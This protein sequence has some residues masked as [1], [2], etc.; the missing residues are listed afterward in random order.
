MK[1][2]GPDHS[3]L[4]TISAFSDHTEE[5]FGVFS[6]FQSLPKELNS[7]RW[8]KFFRQLGL[9]TTLTKNEYKELCNLTAKKKARDA[10][11]CSDVLLQYIFSTSEEII[12]DDW[13]HDSSFLSEVSNIAFVYT[14]NTSSVDWIAPGACQANQLVKLHG[15]ASLGL[16]NCV[17]TVRPIVH[18][19]CEHLIH[20]SFNTA[21][22]S[23]VKKIGVIYEATVTVAD[24]VENV[25]NI[26]KSPYVN[27]NL[28][29]NYPDDLFP[30]PDKIEP[31][32]VFSSLLDVMLD[33]LKTLDRFVDTIPAKTL[34][35]LPCIPVYCDLLNKDA[36]KIVLVKPSCVLTTTCSY[37]IRDYHPFL[38]TLPVESTSLSSQLLAKLG[39]KPSL[40]LHHM[41]VVLEKIY[42][43][44]DGAELDP[45]AAKCVKKAIEHLNNNLRSEMEAHGESFLTSSLSPL[46]LPNKNGI[47]KLSTTLLYCDTPSFK[48]NMEIDLSD[49]C[50]SLFDINRHDHGV[51]ASVLCQ[52][53]PEAVKPLGL[54]VVCRQVPDSDCESVEHT[55]LS[56]DVEKQLQHKSNKVA[57]VEVY[58]S[59]IPSEVSAEVL[60]EIVATFFS[61]FVVVTKYELKMQIQMK[62][63]GDAIGHKQ[64]KY[65][66]DSSTSQLVLYID[67]ELEDDEDIVKE[68]TER[69]YGKVSSVIHDEISIDVKEELFTFTTKYLRTKSDTQKQTLLAEYNVEL[70]HLCVHNF[71]IELGEDVPKHYHFRL[72]QD[73][74]NIFHPMEM[75]GYED[76]ENHFIV[77]QVVYLVQSEDCDGLKK[78]YHI[79]TSK[80][81]EEG[82][83]VSILNL[84]KFLIGNKKTRVK[85][86][87]ED[88]A[89]VPYTDESEI[90][91][92]RR[93][94]YEGDLAAIIEHIRT[95]LKEIWK[96]DRELR[97]KAVKRLYLKWHPDKNL[98]NTE[99]AQEVFIFLKKEIERLEEDATPV[100]A[101]DDYRDT[102][103]ATSMGGAQQFSYRMWDNMASSQ[104]DAEE[105]YARNDPSSSPPPFD[106]VKRPEEGKRWVKQA[107]TDFK[108][109]CDIH[110]G[111]I[112]YA[113]NTNNT[114][115]ENTTNTYANVC[116]MA[117]QV[118]EK[119]L[120]G[121][122]YALCGMDGRGLS[123]HNLTRHAY[124]L[125]TEVPEQAQ[126]L[127]YHSTRLESYYLDTHGYSNCLEG[128][129]DAPAG[130]NLDQAAAAKDHAKAVLD[131]V[132][133][134]M[135]QHKT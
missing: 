76:R 83:N 134:I 60:G 117:H 34:T 45:N 111:A 6:N 78:M 133:S 77:A 127:V 119:A 107:E 116:F 9:K 62:E 72:D 37:V 115:A 93:S 64:S 103:H 124:A 47:L 5:I 12:A 59:L 98:D 1:C 130:Y 79:Y 17:W 87:S 121:G 70:K 41:Q 114:D 54:S 26:C 110:A 25:Q 135:P 48:G 44:S 105:Q 66:L 108:A 21:A 106:R 126:G 75:I 128:C 10:R 125:Q 18:L 58:N 74:H 89:V 123:D 22:C 109:L 4:Q 13:V 90:A 36:R 16:M 104:R 28:F 113:S 15:A 2:V 63:S 84:Y 131:I 100:E 69:L 118:A 19:P 24:V 73:P 97:K 46:H 122:V 88:S 35:E 7:E 96:L 11:K 49:T 95:K 68:V 85:L 31:R 8:L 132:I 80:L 57:I 81:D 3:T 99:I 120:K 91:T 101:G 51:S 40:E 56:L 53:L 33:N 61:S 23:L 94:L 65:Y 43:L 42:V 55:K 29:S 82:K 27:V 67:D 86:P 38:H 102:S 129:T 30:P 39:V 92:L 20:L 112:T 71:N 52:Q 32:R 14:A 50:Y